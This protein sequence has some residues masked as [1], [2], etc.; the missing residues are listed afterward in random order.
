MSIKVDVSVDY[1]R[2]LSDTLA[3]LIRPRP[4]TTSYNETVPYVGHV[5]STVQACLAPL[6]PVSTVEARRQAGQMGTGCEPPPYPG[7]MPTQPMLAAG[8]LST[9]GMCFLNRP[10]VP[11]SGRTNRGDLEPWTTSLFMVDE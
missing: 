3:R 7:V 6:S 1:I 2:T 4:I 9:P 8:T 5:C 10:A 11:L